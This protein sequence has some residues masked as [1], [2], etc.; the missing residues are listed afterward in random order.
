MQRKNKKICVIITSA[1]SLKLFRKQWTYWQ[2]NGWDVSCIAGPGD[3]EHELV[4]GLGVKTHVVPFERLPSVFKDIYCLIKLWRFLLWNR[5]DV[6][7]ISTPKA[8]FI[9]SLAAFLSGHRRVYYLL[10]GRAYENMSGLKR[11]IMMLCE[12]ITCHLSTVVVPICKEMGETVVK[13]GLC[14]KR[15]IRL[16]GSGSSAGVDLSIF[17]LTNEVR[18]KAEQI[19]NDNNVSKADIIL[20][21]VGWFRRDKGTN[22]LISAFEKIVNS[23]DNVKL[24]LVGEFEPGDPLEEN[25]INS[26]KNNPDIIH[27]PWQKD[28]APYYVTADI[29]VFPSYR[30]GFGN[31]AI[32]ASAMGIPVIASDISGC[33][34]AVVD[35]ITGVLVPK[36]DIDG[37]VSAISK[38]I[39]NKEQRLKLGE[40]GRKRVQCDFSETVIFSET[41]KILVSLLRV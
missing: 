9:A 35:G 7:H 33:R 16:V 41:E 4:R 37:L 34:E 36:Q 6:L 20:L 31:V 13:E 15:K 25:V 26:I 19:R 38:L 21:Y 1:L 11:K 29:L 24:M 2:D 32:E 30:E 23:Y 27:I 22:E 39:S 40:C 3:K 8:S 5:Y 28:I 10:R 18:K 14:N 17:S 12:W